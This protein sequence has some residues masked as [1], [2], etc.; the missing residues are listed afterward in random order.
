MGFGIAI[1]HGK[2]RTVKEPFVAFAR[3]KDSVLWN[4]KE[5]NLVNLVFLIGVTEENQDVTHLRIISQLAGKLTDDEFIEK[6]QTLQE[7]D[8]ILHLFKS[9]RV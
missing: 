2:S 8:E 6:L 3:L 7:T 1:P 9:I 5:K 4:E